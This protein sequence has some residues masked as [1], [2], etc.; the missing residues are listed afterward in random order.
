MSTVLT[1]LQAQEVVNQ[2]IVKA[3][4]QYSRFDANK[5]APNIAQAELRFLKSSIN[6]SSSKIFN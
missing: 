1:L 2:G 5:I 6:P 3:T 4:P